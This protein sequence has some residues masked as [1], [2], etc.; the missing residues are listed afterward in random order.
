LA[1]QQVWEHFLSR[2]GKH[3]IHIPWILLL[4][5]FLLGKTIL[6]APFKFPGIMDKIARIY[7]LGCVMIMCCGDVGRCCTS[8]EKELLHRRWILMSFLC[9]FLMLV[10]AKAFLHDIQCSH[11][12]VLSTVWWSGSFCAILFLQTRVFICFAHQN[13]FA[14]K[15]VVVF[16]FSNGA[17]LLKCM[18]TGGHPVHRHSGSFH[19]R[20][21]IEQN[22]GSR[23]ALLHFS[24]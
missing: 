18:G 19:S 23:M 4:A 24:V 21:E 12:L 3:K 11:L 5:I 15:V 16:P 13:I 1:T 9:L 10:V 22:S 17:Q 20:N 7:V 6:V 8:A 14:N 2:T